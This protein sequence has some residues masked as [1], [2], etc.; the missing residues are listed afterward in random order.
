VRITALVENTSEIDGLDAE[1]GLSLMIETEEGRLLFDM[2]QTDLFH[3]NAVKLGIDIGS[4]DWAVLSHGHY[5]HGGG[6]KTFLRYNSRA[7]V[8]LSRYAFDALYN[9]EG[10]YIGLEPELERESRLIF[11]ADETEIT[12]AMRLYSCNDRAKTHG[13][14]T[15]GLAADRDG[16]RI[17][18]DFRHEQYLLIKNGGKRIVISGCSHKGILNILEWLH[19]DVLVGGFHLMKLAADSSLDPYAEALGRS[20]AVLYTCHCTGAEQFD[21]LRKKVPGLRYLSTGQTIDV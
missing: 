16:H 15:F 13:V 12:P 5:D 10:K 20:G 17:P 21:Y 19:P 9:G 6:L 8:Y 1:H 11:T 14:R 7:S 2:G 3:R 4:A 18:D